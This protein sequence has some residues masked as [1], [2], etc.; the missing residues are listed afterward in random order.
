MPSFLSERKKP[1]VNST[2]RYFV[3]IALDLNFAVTRFDFLL[4][5]P[6]PATGPASVTA[7]QEE[8]LCS[9]S[10]SCSHSPLA[11]QPITMLYDCR[12]SQSQE[13]YKSTRLLP[14]LSK[15]PRLVQ[16]AEC[17]ALKTR[18][19]EGSSS[20]CGLWTEQDLCASR[21][22]PLPSLCRAASL[23]RASS[24]STSPYPR[25]HTEPLCCFV[26]DSAS[27]WKSH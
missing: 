6:G 18:R 19:A 1:R 2:M 15:N 12:R 27:W 17:L 11:S 13:S 25:T 9:F 10:T 16:W 5:I 21:C 4:T 3:H 23:T 26:V 7:P 14:S 22:R 24:S 20:P 8:L